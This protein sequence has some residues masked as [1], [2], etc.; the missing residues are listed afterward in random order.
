VISIDREHR[1][2]LAR[3]FHGRQWIYLREAILD[4]TLGEALV[5]DEAAPQ[6]AVLEAPKLKLSIC[7]GEAGHPAARAY[8]K[9]LAAPRAL[10]FDSQ[11]WETLFQAVQRGR[12]VRM[13]RYAFSGEKL[14][15]ER[16]RQLAARLPPGYRVEPVDLRLAEQ[17][18]DENSEF[19][20]EH[21]LN[22]DS[23]E[24]FVRRGFGFAILRGE[25]I[26]SAA[27]TFAVCERGV[28]IHTSTRTGHAGQ[29]LATAITARMIVHCLERGLDPNCDAA[30]TDSAR[31]ALKLGYTPRGSYPLFLFVGSRAAAAYGRLSIW[32]NQHLHPQ[33]P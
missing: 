2:A 11:G 6:V 20:A 4:G 17:L 32:I 28:D 12:W 26:A 24:D 30:H 21:M 8:L 9:D 18:A 1:Q 33:I 14:D 19:T 31:L 5:D 27:T 25:E 7:G 29:G 15:L 22:F 16:L 3:L 23:P 10:I 13:A